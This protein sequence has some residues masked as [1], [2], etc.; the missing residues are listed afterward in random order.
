MK[1]RP[2][3][4]IGTVFGCGL[5]PIAPGT[6]GSAVG[7]AA[8]WALIHFF[9]LPPFYLAILAM[10]LVPIGIWSADVTARMIGKED[11]GMV[12]IDEVLG[13]WI[14]LA[15]GLHVNWKMYL[16]GF[17]LFRLFDIWKPAP[18]R[19]FEN[20]PGG[21]G[22]VADDLMAGLYGALVLFALG[23]FNLY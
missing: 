23:W 22:I 12:V 19:Q 17:G 16:I 1:N 18:A 7:V 3:W 2:A 5:S 9:S 21:Q 10:G 8:A 20:L 14:T 13:Q 6:V 15:G 11:P 4:L